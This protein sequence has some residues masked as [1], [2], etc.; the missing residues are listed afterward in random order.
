MLPS[1][2]YNTYSTMNMITFFFHGDWE[3]QYGLTNVYDVTL[4][5]HMNPM[6]A[7]LFPCS[8]YLQAVPISH[9]VLSSCFCIVLVQIMTD[10]KMPSLANIE[11]Y[12]PPS[13]RET[14]S[15]D[16]IHVASFLVFIHCTPRV[17]RDKCDSFHD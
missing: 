15:I 6:H 12:S 1:N 3:I 10:L 16:A 9:E 7:D 11:L 14:F 17:V 2:L 5:H 4:R 13:C 8:R